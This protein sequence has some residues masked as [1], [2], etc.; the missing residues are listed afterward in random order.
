MDFPVTAEFAAAANAGQLHA[1]ARGA[2]VE[3]PASFVDT[4]DGWVYRVDD[5]DDVT[6]DEPTVAAAIANHTPPDTTP[7]PPDGVDAALKA[8]KG[9]YT[10][11]EAA[12]SSCYTAEQLI[13]EAMAW[14]LA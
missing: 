14:L 6:I 8:V 13:D 5:G 1:E 7:L 3:W 2:S 10:L 9:I 12:D 4:G 11:Q